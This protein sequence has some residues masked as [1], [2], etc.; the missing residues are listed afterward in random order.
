MVD[1]RCPWST[2]TVLSDWR[3]RREH[4]VQCLSSVVV[5]VVNSNGEMSDMATRHRGNP[6]T[7]TSE[8]RFEVTDGLHIHVATS[9]ENLYQQS[10]RQ[11]ERTGSSSVMFAINDNWKRRYMTSQSHWR[12]QLWGT[13]ARAPSTSD[14]VIFQGTSEPHK[15]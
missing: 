3:S 8:T 4:R 5:V 10:N 9:T 14:C 7:Q 12:R 1:G 13:G 2:G 6:P 15:L 11:Q